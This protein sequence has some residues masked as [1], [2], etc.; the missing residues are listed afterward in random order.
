MKSLSYI[1]ARRTNEP[2]N[3]KNA[4]R[5]EA[6]RTSGHNQGHSQVWKKKNVFL[7]MHEVNL[8]KENGCHMA[9][10]DRGLSKTSIHL[11]FMEFREWTREE[12]V[13]TPSIV[14]GPRIGLQTLTERRKENRDEVW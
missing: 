7:D 3:Q 11:E 4:Y 12:K 1:L 2:L 14:K 5:L 8:C 13:T 9:S 10:Q 6:Q